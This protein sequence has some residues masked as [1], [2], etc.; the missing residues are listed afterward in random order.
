MRSMIMAVVVGAAASVTLA[1]DDCVVVP[2][3][4]EVDPAPSNQNWPWN[5][6]FMRY[7][8]VYAADQ[9]NGLTGV[10]ESFAYRID[11]EFGGPFGPTDTQAQIW[12]GYSEN[13]PGFLSTVFDD[14]FSGGKTLVLDGTVTYGSDGAG[15]FDIVMDIDDVFSYDGSANLLMEIIL[16]GNSFSEEFDAAGLGLGQGGTPWTDRLWALDPNATTGN[17][18]GD[19]GPVTKFNFAGGGCAPDCNGDGNLDILDFVCFQG[20]F[21]DQDP[22]ADCDGNGEFNIL[23]FVCFQALFQKGC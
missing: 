22:S 18:G 10:I 9:F 21:L 13:D 12:L 5:N 11:E 8:Q 1:Q 4:N 19:D 7:Q 20:A 6:G 14:N 23:D 3:I 17:L 2:N 15:T 16:P